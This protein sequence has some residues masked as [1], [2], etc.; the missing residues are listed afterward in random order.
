MDTLEIF[1]QKLKISN[2]SIGTD[3]EKWDHMAKT[4][5][6]NQVHGSTYYSDAVPRLLEHKGILNKLSSVLDIGAGSGRYAI[7]L[8]KKC[9][10]VH[11]LDLKRLQL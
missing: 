11:A 8:A 5:Y 10:S 3:E 7:P 4:Y 1:E 6:H 9:Q 2:Q